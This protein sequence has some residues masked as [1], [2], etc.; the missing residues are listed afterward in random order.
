MHINDFSVTPSNAVSIASGTC[1]LKKLLL[2]DIFITGSGN[3][4]RPTAE[5]NE[6][7]VNIHIWEYLDEDCERY[8]DAAYDILSE[9][10]VNFSQC[11][12]L[13]FELSVEDHRNVDK[14]EIRNICGALPCRGVD[15][16]VTFG[17]KK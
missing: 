12:E 10:V 14:T 7:M 15:V 8:V 5:A 3:D 1:K 4:F 11:R 9:F 2:Y 17:N 13:H 16:S 6:E